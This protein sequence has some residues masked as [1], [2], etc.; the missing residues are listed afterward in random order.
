MIDLALLMFLQAS[1]PAAA[2]Q[3]Q[4]PTAQSSASEEEEDK[5]VCTMEP[6]TGTR[7][8]KQKVCKTKGYEKGSEQYRDMLGAIQRASNIEA[9]RAAPSG[10]PAWRARLLAIGGARMIIAIIIAAMLQVAQPAQS[11][12]ESVQ[13][14]AAKEPKVVCTMEPI[15]GTRAKKQKVCK[16]PG[17]EK[18]S[19][20]WRDQIGTIQ[21]GG[22]TLS[23]SQAAERLERFA[24]LG[25]PGAIVLSQQR[26]HFRQHARD[27]GRSR[28]TPVR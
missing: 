19:E 26:A 28:A 11:Q 4:T 22:A 2:P 15:T 5:V 20:A 18:G 3:Q 6:I 10:H 1:S 12:T 25:E 17:Y 9:R 7:A 27:S 13:P 23:L 14:D 16:T 21:R 8:K 24:R